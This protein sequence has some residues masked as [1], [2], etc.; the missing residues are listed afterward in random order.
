M[1]QA[2]LQPF[3]EEAVE[4][5]LLVGLVHAGIGIAVAT[6]KLTSSPT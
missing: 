2:M 3:T 5:E 1:R 4:L 6:V